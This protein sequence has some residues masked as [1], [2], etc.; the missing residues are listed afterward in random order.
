MNARGLAVPFAVLLAVPLAACTSSATAPPPALTEQDLAAD[1]GLAIVPGQ[2]AV[3]FLEPSDA[4]S[5]VADT[6]TVGT[7]VLPLEVTEATSYS[8]A[9]DP[10]DATGTVAEVV[11][12]DEAGA[13]LLTLTPGSPGA[14]LTL[15]PGRYGVT[16]RAGY[17]SA[18]ADL[19]DHRPVFLRP[20]GDASAASSRALSGRSTSTGANAAQVQALLSTKSCQGCDLSGASLAGASLNG[21]KLARANLS[22]ADLTSAKLARAYAMSA[23]FRRA[24]LTNADLTMAYLVKANL[25][26]A[27]TSGA[28]LTNTFLDGATWTDCRVCASNSIGTCN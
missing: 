17:A 1:P 22:G 15:P 27:S 20:P 14:T 19:E 13:V 10:E 28:I 8:L 18:D 11:L 21:A 7:D 3:V 16:I 23:D 6:G 2:I 26:G 4:A 5:D 12:R 25:C 9:L 24:R